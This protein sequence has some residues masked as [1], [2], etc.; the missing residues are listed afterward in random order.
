MGLFE[1]LFKQKGN[2]DPQTSGYWQTLTAYRP[3]FRTRS[4]AAYESELVRS[5]IDARARHIS[6]LK[7]EVRGSAKPKLKNRLKKRPN[8][9]QTWSQWLYRL[10]TILDMQNTAFILPVYEGEFREIT[11]FFPVLPS[12]CSI[13][14]KNGKPFLRYKFRTGKYGACP[15]EEVGIMNKYQYED[16]FFGSTNSALTPTL[17]LIDLNNQGIKESIK[18]SATF[19]FMARL[20]NFAK[21]EDRDKERDEFNN[22]NFRSEAKA[23][24]LLLFPHTWADIKQIESKPFTIDS[25]QLEYIRTNIYNYFGV[26]ENILQNK[27][28][29]DELDAFYN[30]AIEN[31]A[32]QLSDVLT[33]MTYTDREL[34]SSS[35]DG[36]DNE[37][38]VTSNRLQYMSTDKK[39]SMAQQMGDRGMITIDEIRELFNYAPLPNGA[40]NRLPIRGE[41]YFINE[42]GTTSK[43]EG[44]KD[45]VTE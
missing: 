27:A 36:E 32:I 3:V 34:G 26:N 29:G 23:G 10:S 13:V 43:D 11:G 41:Y 8:D 33:K 14:D 39:I 21:R 35:S 24:G 45:N 17:D 16:D 28:N 40:G 31:F 2:S 18:N 7:V 1:S 22:S 4:G 30:G 6:K 38:I 44:D 15:L 42:D 5:A 25:T 12:D 9:F 19:R 20:T 37:I